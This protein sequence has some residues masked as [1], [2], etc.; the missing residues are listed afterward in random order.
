LTR[1][2]QEWKDSEKGKRHAA[3]ATQ[4]LAEVSKK[5]RQ[6]I[7]AREEQEMMDHP[8]KTADILKRQHVRE[9]KTKYDRK[10]AAERA[11]AKDAK[12]DEKI[13]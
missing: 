9:V 1:Q 5:K 3:V 8:E 11:A 2:S 6:H 10:K 12:V 4:M 13:I 7:Y